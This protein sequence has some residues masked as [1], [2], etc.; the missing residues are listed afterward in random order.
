[1][2]QQ[3]ESLESIVKRAPKEATHYAYPVEDGLNEVFFKIDEDMIVESAW[4]PS[5]EPVW[6]FYKDCGYYRADYWEGDMQPFVNWESLI[7]LGSNT[8]SKWMPNTGEIVLFKRTDSIDFAYDSPER[9]EVVTVVGDKVW[10]KNA[11][12]DLVTDLGN[13]APLKKVKTLEDRL[14]EVINPEGWSSQSVS[15]TVRRLVEA[16]IKLEGM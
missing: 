16:G 2:E 13:I 8:H 6:G 1:M 14:N 7:E 3:K 10:L 15:T 4:V 9:M 12:R 5:S 11:L